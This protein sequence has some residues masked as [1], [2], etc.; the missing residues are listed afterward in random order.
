MS[1]P[2][3]K[4]VSS[5]SGKYHRSTTQDP[6]G[7]GTNTTYTS[8]TAQASSSGEQGNANT[9]AS[10][11]IQNQA[12]TPTTIE[13]KRAFLQFLA[14]T[15]IETQANH[16]RANTPTTIEEKRA[17]MQFLAQETAQGRGIVGQYYWILDYRAK[18]WEFNRRPPS[19]SELKRLRGMGR[20]TGSGFIDPPRTTPQ[21]PANSPRLEAWLRE[22]TTTPSNILSETN[23]T[24]SPSTNSI[25]VPPTA[26][27]NASPASMARSRE[28]QG[29]AGIFSGRAVREGLFGIPQGTK[30]TK[31]RGK[32]ESAP[33][34]STGKST[35]LPESS[36]DQD[37]AILESW[38]RVMSKV[39]G[40]SEP[41][42]AR[43]D[44][45]GTLFMW[46]SLIPD[47]WISDGTG[48]GY[49]LRITPNVT[50]NT[51][52]SD[53]GDGS[54]GS[55]GGNDET[56]TSV[57]RDQ[58]RESMRS[59][60]EVLNPNAATGIPE[61]EEQNQGSRSRR[62]TNKD[63]RASP[64]QSDRNIPDLSISND[65]AIDASTAPRLETVTQNIRDSLDS[66]SPTAADDDNQNN[67]DNH[68]QDARTSSGPPQNPTV[69]SVLISNDF[70]A[71]IQSLFFSAGTTSSLIASPNLRG[72]SDSPEASDISAPPERTEIQIYE[73]DTS[74]TSTP[75]GEAQQTRNTDT[76]DASTI[77]HPE[78]MERPEVDRS[79]ESEDEETRENISPTIQP[80]QQC[81][82]RRVQGSP[83]LFQRRPSSE[84]L[85]SPEPR[86]FRGRAP[87]LSGSSRGD[88]SHGVNR[89][90]LAPLWPVI[91]GASPFATEGPQYPLDMG[92]PSR[93]NQE[94][95]MPSSR[96]P[97][98]SW[99]I[100]EGQRRRTSSTSTVMGPPPLP[101]LSEGRR[102][103]SSL[104]RSPR[105]ETPMDRINVP[106][107][108]SGE[109]GPPPRP[110]QREGSSATRSGSPSGI[111][112]NRPRRDFRRTQSGYLRSQPGGLSSTPG[113]GTME[114]ENERNSDQ[115]ARSGNEEPEQ[116]QH[117][118]NPPTHHTSQGEENQRGPSAPSW[119]TDVLTT[120]RQASSQTTDP[121]STVRVLTSI[122]TILQNGAPTEGDTPGISTP[123]Q[124][125]AMPSPASVTPSIAEILLRDFQTG[126]AEE[127]D[128]MASAIDVTIS[129]AT[130][131]LRDLQNSASAEEFREAYLRS[132][133]FALLTLLTEFTRFMAER[134]PGMD[135]ASSQEGGRSQSGGDYGRDWEEGRDREDNDEK[136]D[137]QEKRKPKKNPP[138]KS[139]FK[140]PPKDNHNH[141]P[142]KEND[143]DT[144]GN[145]PGGGPTQ[146]LVLGIRGGSGLPRNP[147]EISDYCELLDEEVGDD[148]EDESESEGEEETNSE[149]LD[150]EGRDVN[151]PSQ[152]EQEQLR[153]GGYL[154]TVKHRG[155]ST[156]DPELPLYQD[157]DTD[158][159]DEDS[160]YD[161]FAFSHESDSES[162][163]HSDSVKVSQE[164]KLHESEIVQRDKETIV[165][166]SKISRLQR[167]LHHL[168]SKRRDGDDY[169]INYTQKDI[170]KSNNP[171]HI[172]GGSSTPPPSEDHPY[173]PEGNPDDAIETELEPEPEAN[174]TSPHQPNPPPTPSQTPS[175]PTTQTPQAFATLLLITVLVAHNLQ[176]Q[177]EEHATLI[178]RHTGEIEGLERR[179]RTL[180]DP[181]WD[182]GEDEE[183]EEEEDEEGEEGGASLEGGDEDRDRDEAG[184]KKTEVHIRGAYGSPPRSSSS[185]SSTSSPSS[186]QEKQTNPTPSPKT[187][188]NSNQEDEKEQT[189]DSPS[190]PKPQA[191]TDLPPFSPS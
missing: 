126:A 73:D 66:S 183:D 65:E 70:P 87:N 124:A 16:W 49:G 190:T 117:S 120:L 46:K 168:L 81:S 94:V 113:Q 55:R 68:T 163:S 51:V 143:D 151:M 27:V 47:P 155:P 172:R 110:D 142:D 52:A 154:T 158:A 150:C 167:I 61:E 13:H 59:Q 101:I 161:D 40:A 18:E 97:S 28:P 105:R 58:S 39:S 21:R 108:P 85:P 185:S 149:D 100:R 179:V 125:A 133:P 112:Q 83:E 57:K 144:A 54:T 72:G 188:T 17:F 173:D 152:Y 129:M 130:I 116:N 88:T 48:V 109:M 1:Q 181:C 104:T 45:R 7:A 191:A 71:E 31:R 10:T 184:D 153:N 43:I 136:Q 33:R 96:S 114:V 62:T 119:C 67:K 186:T 135:A 131:M 111:E 32:T 176:V 36:P 79:E 4:A 157:L 84:D 56:P 134:H 115:P 139:D 160:I 122:A 15:P 14:S 180:E 107:R 92:E 23:A 76:S 86:S 20:L 89:R 166:N 189:P 77:L 140:I 42:N 137:Q 24:G 146:N 159:S 103:T 53:T 30:S 145:N 64:I 12:N 26:A 123:H 102:L 128:I 171:P 75:Q 41:F 22:S 175:Q 121:P 19:S 69:M 156:P 9:N 11:S 60:H 187:P 38:C 29:D 25:S 35:T 98:P 50:S 93:S 177:W 8:S 118:A 5:P 34:E 182:R 99:E 3:R 63:S 147:Q 74:Q 148:E 91:R 174:L 6:R 37:R 132:T 141:N 138:P 44:S 95:R 178:G 169:G 165:H 90:P 127:G 164:V 2:P 82:L 162:H 170:I 80:T 78:Y 106:S